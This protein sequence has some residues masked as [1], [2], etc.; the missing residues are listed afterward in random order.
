[1][2]DSA[3][4]TRQ[5]ARVRIVSWRLLHRATTAGDRRDLRCHHDAHRVR[6][7]CGN[8]QC[9][10][11]F[12]YSGPLAD[13]AS[14]SGE[15]AATRDRQRHPPRHA[16]SH[17][18]AC[19]AARL[20]LL[21]GGLPVGLPVARGGTAT[22][23]RLSLARLLT[24]PLPARRNSSPT[25]RR[26]GMPT[27]EQPQHPHPRFGALSPQPVFEGEQVLDRLVDDAWVVD[28]G[29]DAPP[30]WSSHRAGVLSCHQH[31]ESV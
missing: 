17:P 21:T 12:P 9:C 14:R 10:Y 20:P 15:G 27:L 4:A 7:P 18:L 22:R 11:G 23:Q 3:S 25:G 13:A 1:M 31:V 19:A 2:T 26:W 5:H 29:H 28:V 8:P 6:G 16:R 24:W 30:S